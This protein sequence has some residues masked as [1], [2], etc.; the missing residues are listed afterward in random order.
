MAGPQF[1]SAQMTASASQ[2]AGISTPPGY[3]NAGVYQASLENQM[4]E[5]SQ[6][7]DNECRPL[8]MS[9]YGT[10]DRGQ[11]ASTS[12]HGGREMINKH[13]G[14]ET[15]GV[16]SANNS[17]VLSSSTCSR[18]SSKAMGIRY[19]DFKIKTQEVRDINPFSRRYHCLSCQW[20][21]QRGVGG[22]G[23]P[24]QMAG[25]AYMPCYPHFKFQEGRLQDMGSVVKTTQTHNHHY[26][27]N[28]TPQS[29]DPSSG[30]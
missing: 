12:T 19:W 26:A 22:Y 2:Y 13:L 17:V 3:T 28:E 9:S 1:L 29:G 16:T 25:S 20:Q 27:D 21:Q 10:Q 7:L 15:W 23:F 4:F 6:Q 5:S 14:R 30:A 18:C 8:T 24:S 11:L